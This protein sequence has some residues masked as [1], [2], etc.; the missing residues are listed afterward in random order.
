MKSNLKLHLTFDD[1][2]GIAA[3]VAT[4]LSDQEVNIVF[5]EMD[6]HGA[7]AV[8]YLELET[9]E[10]T[11]WDVHLNRLRTLIGLCDI[12][13]IEALPREAR[14]K[15]LQV[16]LDSIGDGILGIDTLGK[17]VI[18]NKVAQHILGCDGHEITGTDF[19]RIKRADLRLGECLEGKSFTNEKRNLITPDGRFQFLATSKPILDSTGRIVGAVEIM[20]DMEELKELS[21]VVSPSNRFSFSDMIGHSP[22]LT[23]AI[24]FAQKIA[25]ADSV[26]SVFG[27]SGTGKELF[28]TAIHTE[29]G[30]NGPFVPINCAAL[31][32]ALLESEL[33]GYV[34]GAFSGAKKDGK[35][36]LFEIARDGTLFL[37]EIAEMPLVLQA[38]M[39]RVLQEKRIRRIG[40]HDEIPVNA[41]IV[42]ATNKNLA[43]MVEQKL[44]RE[45]LYYRI[46]VFPIYV[47]PLR[48]RREDIP[49]LVEHFLFHLNSSL[50]KNLQSFSTQAMEKLKRHSWPGNIRE[51]KNVVERTSILSDVTVIDDS[52]VLLGEEFGRAI[53]EPRQADIGEL[54]STSL[55]ELVAELEKQYIA[56]ALTQSK[57]K[58]QA[59]RVL[60]LT[61]TALLNR[62]KKYGANL[63]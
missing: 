26:V 41:R 31:P 20:R 45:D 61:H 36:G 42:I 29:S 25:R 32:E 34:G 59:A 47:P 43:E 8:I 14:E 57:S 37:D 38:K 5:F 2:V 56:A 58:R 53:Q 23:E 11:D 3:D 15:R 1:R 51:L 54:E 40:G 44:F 6:V 4:L 62:I 55:P 50:E 46:N 7:Q 30:R 19:R 13:I 60:G 18:I 48:E 24:D 49:L 35:A 9:P 12:A 10:E 28:A 63:E 27:E 33:F 52:Y 16:A 17:V 22:A 39:L 21:T